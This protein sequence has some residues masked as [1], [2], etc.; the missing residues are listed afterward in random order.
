MRRVCTM[1]L[2]MAT[3]WLLAQSSAALEVELT[4]AERLGVGRASEPVTSGVPLPEGALQDPA[5][6]R[7]FD[8]NGAPV[9]VQFGVAN[10]WRGD[11]SIKWLHVD[12]QASVDA[13]Q[14]LRYTLRSDADAAQA[15]PSAVLSVAEQGDGY[16]VDTGPLRFTMKGQGFNLFDQ[17]ELNGTPLLRAGHGG[18]FLIRTP[19]GEFA[20]ASG[21]VGQVVIEEQGPMK[22]VLLATGQHVAPD[23]TGY[24]LD[25][26]CRVYAYAGSPRLKVVY[27]VENRRGDWTDHVA[28]ADWRLQLPWELGGAGAFEFGLAE[29]RSVRGELAGNAPRLEVLATDWYRI[30]GAGTGDR[31]G[32]PKQEDP[33][34]IGA[35][36]LCGPDRGVTVGMRHFWQTWS[37][38]LEVGADGEL[39]IGFWTDRVRDKGETSL[40]DTEGRAQFFAGMAWTHEFWLNFHDGQTEDR[41]LALVAPAREPLFARC[42]PAWYCMGTRVFGNLSEA[43]PEVYLPEWRERVEAVSAWADSS[44]DR[45][46]ARWHSAQAGKVDSFGMFS[47]GDGIEQIKGPEPVNVHWEGG[48]Y[49]YPHSIFLHFARTGDL[50]RLWQAYDMSR[51]NADVHHTHHDRHPGRAR[52]CP[53]REHIRMDR[54]GRPP[55]ASPTFNH[56]KNLSAFERWWLTGDHRGREAAIEASQWALRLGNNGIDFGQP[57]SIC[58]ALLGLWAA[59]EGTGEAVYAEALQSFARETARRLAGGRRMGSGA[60]QR[61]MAIQGLSWYVEQTG[62]ESVMPGIEKAIERDIGSGAIEQAYGRIFM[63]NRTG[64]PRY[65]HAAARQ[66]RGGRGSHWMQRFGNYGRSRLYAPTLVRKDAPRPVP[67]E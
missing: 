17:V 16:R 59:H 22:V 23:G 60:W 12:F 53:S 34:W 31:E 67:E 37:K 58:H 57:R 48:Y 46:M 36:D 8:A 43:D 5:S 33:P 38:Y 47:Y 9:P 26:K 27:T 52:Y 6:L 45:A 35:L 10:R 56:W 49:D 15:E 55:F 65:F 13:G 40:V 64:D 25:Y 3:G 32:N 7:L 63:W 54:A 1:A 51:H 4:V 61:G 24:A 62:D 19:D 28:V 39:S 44:I 50:S 30:S 29:G 42:P 66:I 21:P 18:G 2:T 14:T 11:D 20:P 41:A